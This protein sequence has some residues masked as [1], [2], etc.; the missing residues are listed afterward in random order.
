MCNSPIYSI[1][2]ILF[3]NWTKFWVRCIIIVQRVIGNNVPN[4]LQSTLS[5]N[6]PANQKQMKALLL[7]NQEIVSFF[8]TPVGAIYLF[9]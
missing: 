3:I 4:K 5:M 6:P 7:Y 9:N 8:A 1:P 2:H